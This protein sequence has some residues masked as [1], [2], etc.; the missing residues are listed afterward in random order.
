LGVEVEGLC[1]VGVRALSGRR[2]EIEGLRG[3]KGVEVESPGCRVRIGRL[4]RSRV[5]VERLVP[6][7]CCGVEIEGLRRRQV[8]AK[9]LP[10]WSRERRD[11][12]V[13]GLGRR[14]GVRR[15]GWRGVE[16]KTGR[17]GWLRG[18]RGFEVEG[19]GWGGVG[20]EVE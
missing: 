11:V 18:R 1:W 6:R 17:L 5:E 10:L 2:V 16:V 15:F 3:W 4:G 19:M 12:K 20:V 8:E 9:S 13:E 7:G 14:A